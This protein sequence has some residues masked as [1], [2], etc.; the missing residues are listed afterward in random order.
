MDHSH[1]T[2]AITLNECTIFYFLL[3]VGQV[4]ERLRVSLEKNTALEEELGLTKDEVILCTLN[5]CALV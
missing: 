5:S 4:R 3:F 1:K 2:D